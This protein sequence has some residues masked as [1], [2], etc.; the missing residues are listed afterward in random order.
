MSIGFGSHL[1]ASSSQVYMCTVDLRELGIDQ[2][3]FGINIASVHA[4]P[5]WSSVVLL[6]LVRDIMTGNDCW[7]DVGERGC[8]FKHILRVYEPNTR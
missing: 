6:S 3:S 7:A 4:K 5:S 8:I 2:H 1:N